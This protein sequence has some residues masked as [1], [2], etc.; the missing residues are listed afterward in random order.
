MNSKSAHYHSYKYGV[1]LI[2]KTIV[3]LSFAYTFTNLIIGAPLQVP[4]TEL[5]EMF[6]LEAWSQTWYEKTTWVL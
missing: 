6:D 1:S 3:P 5:K 2:G 4:P